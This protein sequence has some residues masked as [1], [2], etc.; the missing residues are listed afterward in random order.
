MWAGRHNRDIEKI[1]ELLPE[2]FLSLL[3]HWSWLIFVRCLTCFTGL[4]WC[5]TIISFR[6][7]L[8]HQ[9]SKMLWESRGR[10]IWESPSQPSSIVTSNSFHHL[11]RSEDDILETDVE[12]WDVPAAEEDRPQVRIR[13]NPS[14]GRTVLLSSSNSTPN[15]QL[16]SDELELVLIFGIRFLKVSARHLLLSSSHSS[17]LL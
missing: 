12:C 8:I 13:E 6:S 11:I 7:L 10:E 5:L 15:S 9:D 17:L 2:G 4:N 1:L 3:P 16:P 14:E